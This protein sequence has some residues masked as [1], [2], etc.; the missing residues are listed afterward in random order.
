M[1]A[2]GGRCI[3]RMA[4]KERLI[5]PTPIKKQL[6]EF[7]KLTE[8]FSEEFFQEFEN[9]IRTYNKKY[10]SIREHWRRFTIFSRNLK[11]IRQEQEKTKNAVFDPITPFTDLD[12]EELKKVG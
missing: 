1:L 10:S 4:T 11:E 9:F 5:E 2:L 7:A 3:Y 8:E 12:D 6:N